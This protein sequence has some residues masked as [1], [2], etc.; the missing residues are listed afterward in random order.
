MLK[1]N[2]SVAAPATKLPIPCGGEV[3]VVP[4][5]CVLSAHGEEALLHLLD[6][7]Q[8]SGAVAVAEVAL[9]DHAASIT[10]NFR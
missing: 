6:N 7:G 4:Q 1:Y 2:V 9:C 3:A 10:I 5:Q 8:G